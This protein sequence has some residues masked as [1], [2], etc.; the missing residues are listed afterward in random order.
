MTTERRPGLVVDERTLAIGAR[1]D[2]AA[3]P[4]EDDGCRAPAIEDEDRLLSGRRVETREGGPEGARQEAA[5]TRGELRPQIDDL[6]G[7]R[8]PDRPGRE[9][10]PI[11][12]TGP[13]AADTINGGRRRPE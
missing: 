10:Y 8:R 6:D 4:A 7:R 13:S 2:V 3:I 1:L 5:L 12:L 11:V 9:D